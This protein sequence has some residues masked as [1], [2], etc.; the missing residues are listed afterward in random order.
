M[1]TFNLNKFHEETKM[2]GSLIFEFKLGAPQ[3]VAARGSEQAMRILVMGDFSGRASRALESGADLATRQIRRIDIDNVEQAPGSLSCALELALDGPGAAPV[4]IG[5]ATFDDFH[6]DQLYRNPDLFQALAG[7]R[8]RLGNPATFAE[9][10][11][12]LRAGMHLASDEPAAAT[13]DETSNPFVQLLGGNMRHAPHAPEGHGRPVAGGTSGIDAFIKG[14]VGS[15]AGADPL[16]SQYIAAADTLAGDRMRALLHDPAFRSLEAAWRSLHLLV[17]SLELDEQ[18]QVHVLDVSKAE[19]LADVQ[20]AAADLPVSGLYRL[21]VEQARLSPDSPPWSVLVGNYTFDNSVDDVA[22][23]AA[24]GAIG[25]QAGAPFLAAP[26]SGVADSAALTA[27]AADPVHW[28]PTDRDGAARW[29]S[30]R[31]SGQ[32]R[33]IGLALPHLLLRLPYGKNTDRIESFNFEELTG[34]PAHDDYVWGNAAFGCALLLG[35]SFEQSGWDMQPGDNLD[36][37]DLPA[38]TCQRDGEAQLQACGGAYLSERAGAA[39]LRHGPMPLLSFKNR[40]AVRLLRFQSI[41]DP[42]QELAGPWQD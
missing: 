16:Q 26:A 13:P 29:L 33:W 11:A 34:L 18:L 39:I 27:L 30:L 7:L 19:L 3:E 22:L 28:P 14:I 38:H 1:K 4:R 32:A 42:V 6:P 12:Q 24:L 40:N 25:A 35:R 20:A 2:P 21:L 15:V 41:A 8:T 9:A 36:I 37:A 23:L 5:L 31:H 17:T 10:A